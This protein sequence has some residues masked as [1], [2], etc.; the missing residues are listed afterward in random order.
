MPAM[1]KKEKKKTFWEGSSSYD[2]EVTQANLRLHYA[3][4]P[5]LFS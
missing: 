4:G 5:F 1:G 3:L 2:M